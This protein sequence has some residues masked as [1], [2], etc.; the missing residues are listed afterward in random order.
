MNAAVE[1]SVATAAGPAYRDGSPQAPVRPVVTGLGVLAPSGIGTEEYWA[2]TLRGELKI[3]PISR[4]DTTWY[5]ATLAGEVAGFAVEDYVDKRYIVQTDRWTWFGMAASRLAMT[6]ARYD[7]AAH[8]PYAT[9]VVFGSGSGG[10]DIGQREL[11]RLWTRGRTAVSVYQSIAWFYAATTGQTSIRY[12]LKGPSGVLVSDGAGGIDS[13]AQARRIIRR[14]TP[15]VLAGGAEASLTPYAIAGHLSGGRVSTATVAADGYKPFD[16]RANGYL[17]GEGG[18]TLVLEDPAAAAARGAPHVYGEIAGYAATHDA[19]H[20]E[21]PAPDARWLATAMRRALRDASL[22]PDDVDVVFADGAGSPDLDAQEAAAIRT[23]FGARTVPVTA[24]QGFVGRL[25][26]GGSAL[27]VAAA[28]LSIRDGVIPAVGN[29]DT[30]DPAHGLDLVR[31]PR[32]VPVRV[33]LVNARGYGGF[34]SS[35]VVR[36]VGPC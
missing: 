35:L 18:A 2:S 21:R 1:A 5:D 28:L 24:P 15:T 22:T 20:H 29:L 11:G 26:A 32:R 4:F 3:A 16:V 12:G 25:L 10:V 7:P 14:G 36:A 9:S 17:P 13:L 8:D 34:N 19:A 30:P 33:A 6:D 23:V 27:T 31:T